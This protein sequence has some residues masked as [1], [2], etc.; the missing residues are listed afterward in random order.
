MPIYAFKCDCGRKA[1]EFRRLGDVQPPR[2]GEDCRMRQ[3]YRIGKAIIRPDG[4]NLR[5]DDKGYWDF[6]PANKPG[7]RAPERVDPFSAYYE[8]EADIARAEAEGDDG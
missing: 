1:D 7:Y 5:P 6:G 8:A 4:Y 3:D 2:C